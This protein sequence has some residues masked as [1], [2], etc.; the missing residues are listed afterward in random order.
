MIAILR[1]DPQSVVIGVRP[2]AG[3]SEGL[4]AIARY[5]ERNTQNVNPLIVVG[6]D[7]NLAV[8]ERPRAKVVELLPGCPLVVGAKYAANL[9]VV[10]GLRSLAGHGN[11]GLFS[12]N[13]RVNDVWGFAENA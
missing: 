3:G 5:E 7:T 4:A 11:G 9:D 12:F 13:P 8:I 10:G 2:G 1:I 6:I